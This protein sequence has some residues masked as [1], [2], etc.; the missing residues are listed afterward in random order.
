MWRNSRG[1]NW[2]I[3]LAGFPIAGYNLFI[4]DDHLALIAADEIETKGQLHSKIFKK[5][6]F[7]CLGSVFSFHLVLFGLGES[8]F[9]VGDHIHANSVC[10]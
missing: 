6:F 8:A 5:S 1:I 10:I 4:K 3:F 7:V 2:D 9:F